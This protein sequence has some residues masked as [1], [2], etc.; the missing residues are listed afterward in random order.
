MTACLAGGIK[1]ISNNMERLNRLRND[2]YVVIIIFI[3]LTALIV[4]GLV[5]LIKHLLKVVNNY[6]KNKGLREDTSNSAATG[7]SSIDPNIDAQNPRDKTAD[8]EVYDESAVDTKTS[9]VP[10]KQP[11]EYMETSKL[12]FYKT[13]ENA[14]TDYNLQKSKY[15]A[16]TYDGREN[17][18]VVDKKVLYPDYDDYDYNNN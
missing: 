3:V 9:S 11:Y 14:Y 1:S 6:E 17:D 10:V 13:M 4:L 16:N 5:Y 2:C 8:D 12:D 7:T 18:D 15:I